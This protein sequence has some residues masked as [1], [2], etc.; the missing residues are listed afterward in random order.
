MIEAGFVMHPLLEAKIVDI[1]ALCRRYNV[2]QLAVVGS[3]ARGKDFDAAGSDA[4]FL[5]DFDSSSDLSALE[6]FF[7]L[8]ADLSELLD[9][10]VD[11]IERSAIRNPY[12]LGSFDRTREVVYGT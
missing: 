10:P 9:R 11:L 6:Q 1:A 12:L 7:G 5:V 2:R 8:R 3:A 4:D